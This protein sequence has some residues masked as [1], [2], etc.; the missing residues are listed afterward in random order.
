MQFLAL[1]T[2]RGCWLR[3]LRLIKKGI[4]RPSLWHSNST[5]LENKFRRQVCRHPIQ[6][7]WRRE[8]SVGGG[9]LDK[10]V[11]P[12]VY[13]VGVLAGG[14]SE[15]IWPSCCPS[16]F[17]LSLMWMYFFSCFLPNPLSLV[18]CLSLFVS[19]S[20]NVCPCVCLSV[21]SMCF[22]LSFPSSSSSSSFFCLLSFLSVAVTDSRCLH[23]RWNST[24]A[25]PGKVL[26]L[27]S[28]SSSSALSPLL[29]TYRIK[30][31]SRSFFLCSSDC[32]CS[33]SLLSYFVVSF[34]RHRKKHPNTKNKFHRHILIQ[35][36]WVSP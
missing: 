8:T 35:S 13:P 12:S 29:S 25:P 10:S 4:V 27:S 23:L 24:G 2:R 16:F 33:F 32:S 1:D 21:F 19:L 11:Y 15:L 22:F 34:I 17:C 31:A 20:I 3:C 36:V 26:P 28:S 5:Y 9:W 14:V 7:S 18:L 6:L 30:L